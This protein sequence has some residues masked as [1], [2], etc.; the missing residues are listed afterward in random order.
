MALGIVSVLVNNAAKTDDDEVSVLDYHRASF[1]AHQ[2]VTVRGTFFMSQAVARRMVA[3]GVGGSIINVASRVGVQVQSGS[4]GYAIAKAAVIHMTRVM[5]LDLAQPGDGDLHVTSVPLLRGYP[6]D[7]E[8]EASD[9]A[10][11]GRR[12]DRTPGAAL[13]R[14]LPS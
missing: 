5:A 4:L 2:E 11:A 9:R 14:R 10:V 3:A 6:R 1:D 8:H 13:R 7:V 12:R